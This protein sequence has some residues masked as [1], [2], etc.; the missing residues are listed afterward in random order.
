MIILLSFIILNIPVIYREKVLSFFK[1][2]TS[3]RACILTP[4]I[5]LRAGSSKSRL[6]IS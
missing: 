6:R 2:R 1:R 5:F 3:L 4:D